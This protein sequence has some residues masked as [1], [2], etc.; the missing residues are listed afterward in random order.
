MLASLFASIRNSDLLREFDRLRGTNL[1]RMGSQIETM[2]D[3]ATGRTNHDLLAFIEFVH[4]CVFLPLKKTQER[5][6]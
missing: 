3:E 2:I 6:P 1:R 5:E 4:D